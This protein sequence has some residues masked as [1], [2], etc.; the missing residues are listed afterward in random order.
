MGATAL[1][2]RDS[3]NESEITKA[4][5]RLAPKFHKD[6]FEGRRWKEEGDEFKKRRHYYRLIL[7]DSERFQ[8]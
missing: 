2:Q 8:N 3:A 7:F 4:C 1:K 6:E 5:G